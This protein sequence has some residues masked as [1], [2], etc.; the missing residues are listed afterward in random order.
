MRLLNESE[1][2]ARECLSDPHPLPGSPSTEELQELL[3]AVLQ[4]KAVENLHQGQLIEGE[5]N[6][7]EALQLIAAVLQTVRS[8]PD[9]AKLSENEKD[10]LTAARQINHD[11]LALGLAYVRL[12]LGRTEESL[13]LY[14][15]AIAG[16]REIFERRSAMLPLKLE[17]GGHLGNYGQSLMWLG[18]LDKAAPMIRESLQ[19]LD[20]VHAADPQKADYKRQLS[21]ALY[22]MATLRDLQGESAEATSLQE[23][24]RVMRQELVDASNDEKN[25][26]NLMLINARCGLVEPA[27]RL[28]DELGALP[29][30]N[31][32]LQLE[33]ARALAQLSVRAA[34][35]DRAGLIEQA[36]TA[37]ERAV[38]EGYG[39]AFRVKSEPDLLPLR[40]D[41]RFSQVLAGLAGKP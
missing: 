18:Q 38:S 4:N 15:Q 1:A 37:L 25:Q 3:S 28:I 36:L 30:K 33:R 40:N 27:R 11:K 24:C 13:V 16:R 19:L 41:A 23:R 12:R 34:E 21:L 5:K 26:I 35:A 8:A 17:L 22:R 7:A 10:A 6:F 31:G 2:L 39:D 14:D 20:E 9:F 32:E 29:A